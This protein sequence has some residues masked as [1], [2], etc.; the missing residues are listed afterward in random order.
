MSD[1]KKWILKLQKN[2]GKDQS[3]RN[4]NLVSLPMV[5]INDLLS[6]IINNGNELY[7]SDHTT[8][9]IRGYQFSTSIY[10]FYN[11]DELCSAKR[12]I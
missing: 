7:I 10:R 5:F 2:I 11:T 1:F 9:A 12:G 4:L 8:K 6:Q 3:L